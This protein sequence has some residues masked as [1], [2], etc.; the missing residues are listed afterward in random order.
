MEGLIMQKQDWE[1]F[2][3]N[4]TRAQRKGAIML[5]F[6]GYH[7][8]QSKMFTAGQLAKKIG[9]LTDDYVRGLC[10]ELVE[11][12]RLTR[13]DV[14]HRRLHNGVTIMKQLFGLPHTTLTN[15]QRQTSMF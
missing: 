1:I 12:G 9:L 4:M 7:Q 6:T 14:E 11:E 3:K 10:N 2:R 5:V 8:N 13:T 15:V